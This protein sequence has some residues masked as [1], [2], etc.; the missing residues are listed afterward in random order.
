MISESWELTVLNQTIRRKDE[1]EEAWQARQAKAIADIN[2]HSLVLFHAL[3][4]VPPL[5][6]LGGS[7]PGSSNLRC[8]PITVS[9]HSPRW[10]S[11]QG[12]VKSLWTLV[13]RYLCPTHAD[14]GPACKEMQTWDRSL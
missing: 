12:N 8:M 5:P 9:Q 4:Q 6:L 13:H 1:S 11:C 3:I 10:L 14:N 2:S 7:N